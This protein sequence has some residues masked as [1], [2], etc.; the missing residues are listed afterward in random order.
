[1]LDARIEGRART[2]IRAGWIAEVEAILARG[3]DPALKPLQAI[4]YREVVALVRG[5]CSEDEA[6]ARIEAATRRFSRRQMTWFNKEPDIV[7]HDPREGLDPALER[8][9]DLFVD[10]G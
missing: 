2:M 10:E 9:I 3:Y 1:V 4:G 8:R 5:E 7:W 6:A